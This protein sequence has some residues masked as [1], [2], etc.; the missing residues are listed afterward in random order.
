MARNPR[1]WGP[2]AAEFKPERW[3]DT[4]TGELLS[5]PASKFFTFGAGPRTCLGIKLGMLNLRVLTANLLHRYK[6]EIDPAND[7]SHIN[8]IVLAMKH[9]LMAKVERA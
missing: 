6:F 1:V 5:F 3:I 2:D 9:T 7:G 4:K 8:A